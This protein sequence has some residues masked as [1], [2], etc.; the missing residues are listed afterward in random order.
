MSITKYNAL[1]IAGEIITTAAKMGT[2]V[3]NLKLQKILYYVQAK[4]LLET[5]NALFSDE[6]LAW[7][8]GPVV[9]PAFRE[10]RVYAT[11]VITKPSFVDYLK[12]VPEGIV[13]EYIEPIV[14]KY[15]NTSAWDLAMQTHGETPWVDF[16]EEGNTNVIPLDSI[17]DYFS[18]HKEKIS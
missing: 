14:Q 13:K 6:I 7:R 8:F 11:G 17:R 15:K 1:D 16:Y 12:K 2:P 3:S 4:H 9:Y 10:Y 5:G 18:N